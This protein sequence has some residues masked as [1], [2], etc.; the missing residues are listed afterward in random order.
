MLNVIKKGGNK[1]LKKTRR[2]KVKDVEMNDGC[3]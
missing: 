1:Q 3:R 2:A